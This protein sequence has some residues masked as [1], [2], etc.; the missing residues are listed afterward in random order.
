MWKSIILS[1]LGETAFPYCLFVRY[2]DF[3]ELESIID[4]HLNRPA[5]PLDSL[6]VAN[7]FDEEYSSD[8]ISC[9][10]PIT[11][12]EVIELVGDC[13]MS[14][15]NEA[16]STANLECIRW[17]H[18]NHVLLRWISRLPNLK[19]LGISD[20]SNL[21][22]L[23][24]TISHNC[25][26]FH[27]LVL[28]YLDA[29]YIQTTGKQEHIL[30]FRGLKKNTLRRLLI[31]A[32]YP[33]NIFEDHESISS[34]NCHAESLTAL[35]I[36]SLNME[37]AKKL[38][39]L[40]ACKAITSLQL[41]LEF[42]FPGDEE[43]GLREIDYDAFQGMLNWICS[44]RKLRELSVGDSYDG[45]TILTQV[46]SKNW[47]R[48]R[49]VEI[50]QYF[51]ISE[52]GELLQALSTQ[53]TL[54]FLRLR[55]KSADECSPK[56]TQNFVRSIGC[57]TNLKYLDVWSTFLPYFPIDIVSYV[58]GLEVFV[59]N[60][61]GSTDALWSAMAKLHNLR[62]LVIEGRSYF[63][64]DGILTFINALPATYKGFELSIGEQDYATAQIS[65]DQVKAI[66][67]LLRIKL[68]GLFMLHHI[69]LHVG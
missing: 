39:F 4:H 30:F 23:A 46:C 18:K 21:Q 29:Q 20:P 25:P 56:L 41:Q 62:A 61:D 64:F 2:L 7:M 57:L 17:E 15:I 10:N 54:E 43:I 34:I 22:D 37:G 16:S 52:I 12:S 51:K 67:E 50:L 35:K 44:C 38:H 36:G 66:A 47:I 69:Q 5:G 65:C 48:L 58:S 63:S 42:Y 59:I 26:K 3:S 33:W 32:N 60:C 27:T 6:Y 45:K 49:K 53:T 14:Y 31:E 13:L 40:S 55:V 9:A 24:K 19:T 28:P 11:R 8:F 1:S 68:G